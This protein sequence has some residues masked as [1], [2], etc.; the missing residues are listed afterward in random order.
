[1]ILGRTLYDKSNPVIWMDPIARFFVPRGWRQLKYT[2]SA[3]RPRIHSLSS[4]AL[5]HEK[6][7]LIKA[8]EIV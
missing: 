3:V 1:M 7:E 4:S 5:L 2:P 6:P 8:L